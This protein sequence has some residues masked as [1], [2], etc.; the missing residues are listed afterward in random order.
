MAQYGFEIRHSWT[1][2]VADWNVLNRNFRPQINLGKSTNTC[3]R[4]SCSRT[5]SLTIMTYTE[6]EMESI[7]EKSRFVTLGHEKSVILMGHYFWSSWSK[8]E[9]DSNSRFL[10]KIKYAQIPMDR[11]VKSIFDYSP[12][13]THFRPI[14]RHLS[15]AFSSLYAI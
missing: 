4:I 12:E 3:P 15:T 2:K 1:L 5:S 13:N 7:C 10:N 6:W 9:W 11:Y 8:Q 14:M